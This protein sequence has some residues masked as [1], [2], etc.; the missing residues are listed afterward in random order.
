MQKPLQLTLIVILAIAL[1]VCAADWDYGD[2]RRSTPITKPKS[3]T[4]GQCTVT[5]YE[6]QE[7]ER[8]IVVRAEEDGIKDVF[9][10]TAWRDRRGD[11]RTRSF[12]MWI[13]TP[14][15]TDGPYFISGCPLYTATALPREVQELGCIPD[16]E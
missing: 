2:S 4:V 3:Y 8:H 1:P 10:F 12:R 13:G 15:P 9:N 16:D 5:D 14:D 7:G 11:V 6:T